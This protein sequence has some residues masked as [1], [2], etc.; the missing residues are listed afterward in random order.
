MSLYFAYGSNMLKSRMRERI[1]QASFFGIGQLVGYQ[2][3]CNKRGAKGDA[4]ANLKKKTGWVTW[5]VLYEFPQENFTR[6]DAYE[7]GYFREM[8]PVVCSSK[9]LSTFTYFSKNIAKQPTN[10]EYIKLILDGAEE[11]HLPESYIEYL[12]TFMA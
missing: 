6:L 9:T 5:G 1:P 3:V 2:V 4:K 11:H 8:V 7:K 12:R 10:Y